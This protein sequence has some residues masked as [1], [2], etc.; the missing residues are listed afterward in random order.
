[1]NY[2]DEIKNEIIDIET[3]K[4]VKDYSKNKRELEGYY[5][6]GKIIID[7]QGGEEKATYGNKLIKEYSVKL[8]YELGKGY[9]TTNLKYMRQFYLFIKKGQP[10]ADQLTWSHYLILFSIKDRNKINYYI[11][12]VEKYNLSKRELREKIKSKEYERLDKKTKERLIENQENKI[13]D[14]IKHPILIK[15]TIDNKNI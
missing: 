9:S 2:Y 13:Q 8:T 1:M 7:A 3:Y 10:V 14:F 4:K 5:K 15:N 11:N 12:Q 6:I